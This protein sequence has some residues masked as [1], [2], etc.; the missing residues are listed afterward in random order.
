MEKILSIFKNKFFLGFSLIF[1]V[2]IAL[3]FSIGLICS[4]LINEE[5]ICEYFKKNTGL[6]LKLS[7][8]RIST[9]ADLSFSVKADEVLLSEDSGTHL[10]E[11][12][13]SYLR[14]RILPL[15][16]KKLSISNLSA[17]K[18]KIAISR[19]LNGVFNFEKYVTSTQTFPLELSLSNTAIK[20]N[21]FN[22]SFGDDVLDK[23]ILITSNKINVSK[24]SP[25]KRFF[26]NIV[27]DLVL[28]DRKYNSKMTSIFDVS[29]SGKNLL[30]NKIKL[31]GDKFSLIID[32]K[33]LNVFSDKRILNISAKIDKSDLLSIVNFVPEGVIPYKTDI[34]KE[35]KK[36][37]PY[38]ILSGNLDIN[39]NDKTPNVTGKL[40]FDDV[41][42]FE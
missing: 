11:L 26:G 18:V 14:V 24:F 29:G 9:L 22:L 35:L 42:L 37:Q 7:S 36:A 25:N 12:K 31:N 5:N 10:L 41:Y 2:I 28:F 21:D 39:G 34:I 4:A 33:I 8:A 20:I 3:Y 16:L 19:D 1:L 17:D 32:G 40:V 30:L 38:A 27:A 13:N 6:N 15:I 23:N